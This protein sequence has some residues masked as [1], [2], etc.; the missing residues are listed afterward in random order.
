MKHHTFLLS[1]PWEHTCPAAATTKLNRWCPDT[2]S[3]SFPKTL[4]LGTVCAGHPAWAKLDPVF[5]AWSTG[6]GGKPL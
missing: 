1:H 6:G 2:L 4:Q 5:P 3:L